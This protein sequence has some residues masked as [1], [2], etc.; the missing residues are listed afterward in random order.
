MLNLVRRAL[1]GPENA[2]GEHLV[3]VPGFNILSDD[4]IERLLV[5][6]LELG[7]PTTRDRFLTI[8]HLSHVCSR[9]RQ[10]TLSRGSFWNTIEMSGHIEPGPRHGHVGAFGQSASYINH[11]RSHATVLAYF[12]APIV[13]R[14][15]GRS[16]ASV[17]ATP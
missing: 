7:P 8:L 9:V 12:A 11:P 2:P 14:S 16:R 5:D 13:Q 15:H 4:L 6:V 3:V 10:V 1:W 17:K